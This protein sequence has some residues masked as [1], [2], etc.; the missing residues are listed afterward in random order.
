MS[1]MTIREIQDWPYVEIA[2][3]HAE[4]KTVFGKEP[5]VLWV[6]IQLWRSLQEA[7]APGSYDFRAYTVPVFLDRSGILAGRDFIFGW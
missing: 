6:G 3:L 5:S 2:R 1:G 7:A 4:F